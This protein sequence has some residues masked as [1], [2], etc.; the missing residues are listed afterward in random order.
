MSFRSKLFFAV[1]LFF[2]LSHVLT[3]NIGMNLKL[4][5][6]LCGILVLMS[7][8]HIRF[9]G[10]APAALLLALLIFALGLVPLFSNIFSIFHSDELALGSAKLGLFQGMGRMDPLVAPWIMWGWNIFSIL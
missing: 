9:P 7:L 1:G 8:R 2:T 10:N 3:I 5:E 6:I 4:P